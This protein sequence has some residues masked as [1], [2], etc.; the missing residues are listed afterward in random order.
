[1][2]DEA[3]AGQPGYAAALA[4]LQA[5]LA[6]LEGDHVDVDA[7]AALVRRAA[8]LVRVCQDRIAGARLEIERVVAEL[9]PPA[10]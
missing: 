4:E 5:I 7:L 3:A 8:D 6:E 1:M 10:R 2:A 9:D